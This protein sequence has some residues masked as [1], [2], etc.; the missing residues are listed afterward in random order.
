[1]KKKGAAVS[2]V[3]CR[4]QPPLLSGNLR[5]ASEMGSVRGAYESLGRAAGGTDQ[6]ASGGRPGLLFKKKCVPV[7]D[8]GEI[9]YT[10]IIEN[11]HRN[12]SAEGKYFHLHISGRDSVGDSY[13]ILVTVRASG[14]AIQY[15]RTPAF[16]YFLILIRMYFIF[17]EGDNKA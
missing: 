13:R 4:K 3:I 17:V 7:H 16:W 6:A 11:A 9:N 8:T 2:A 15:S 10:L 5:R 1:M 14:S 12:G